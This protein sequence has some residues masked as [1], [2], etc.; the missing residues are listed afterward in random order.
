MPG[1]IERLQPVATRSAAQGAGMTNGDLWIGQGPL[2]V[3]G[4]AGMDLYADPPGTQAAAAGAFMAALGGSAGNIAAGLARLGR[5]VGLVSA[6]S[7]DAVG[8]FVLGQLR[9]YGIGADHVAVA[10]GA[11]RTSLAVTETREQAQ[12][13]IYRN[14]AADFALT[15]AQVA[16]I[17]M[18]AQGALV[19][20]GTAL[21]RQPS[22]AA[23]L[24]AMAMARAAGRP[25]VLDID[26]RAYSWAS[27]DEVR[28]I[29]MAAAGLSDMV[30][31][32]DLE[33]DM[34]AGGPQGRGTAA[35]LAAGGHIAVYKMG[36]EGSETFTPAGSFRTGIFRVTA[37]KPMGAGDAFMA[38]LLDGLAGGDTLPAAVRRGSAAAAIVVAGIGCAPAMPD[39]ATL[40][41]FLAARA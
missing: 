11:A 9:H 35:A 5:A 29:C 2:L 37:R 6:V 12:T 31:G 1:S 30:V 4:R 36:A 18:A 26:Y 32:N 8:R 20:T 14:E 39:R 25:V 24:A 41:A 22:R 28:D 3:L 16:R 13:V 15:E 33:F 17:A 23:T 34:L 7:D 19:V 10:G 21:A 40:E 27:G 38:G